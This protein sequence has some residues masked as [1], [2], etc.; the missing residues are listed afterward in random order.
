MSLRPPAQGIKFNGTEKISI[1]ILRRTKHL[2][3]NWEEKMSM[4]KKLVRL[5]HYLSP[6]KTHIPIKLPLSNKNG[7]GS[8]SY[9]VK[10]RNGIAKIYLIIDCDLIVVS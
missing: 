10:K 4:G 8:D 1:E 5:A 6:I 9:V 7:S 2:I 3:W